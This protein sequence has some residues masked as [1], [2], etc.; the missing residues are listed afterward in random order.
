L[1]VDAACSSIGHRLIEAPVPEI[2]RRC[3]LGMDYRNR[4]VVVT[5]GAGALGTALIAALVGAGAK[6][7]VA[8][9]TEA[10]ARQFA[11]RE[12]ADVILSVTGD[13]SDEAAV[14][15]LFASVPELWAAMHLAGGFAAASAIEV[16]K[17]L[18]LQQLNTNFVS[19]FL[20]CRAALSA[21]ARTCRGGRIVNVAA[22]P[23]LE[24][25]AG[26]G[27]TA[28]AASKAAVA[29][30]T[31]ALGEEVAGQNILVNAVAPSILDTAANRSSMPNADFTKWPKVEDVAA[32]ILFLGSPENRVT[33]SAVVPVYGRS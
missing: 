26:A 5:G 31:V 9:T 3:G 32:T 11:L 14:A 1:D 17:D 24:W 28:Y 30:L 18:L 25:R 20:C 6:C 10:Q 21:M 12:H 8:C 16:S 7:H 33:R 13:L 19:C 27:M 22:R 4:H 23:A 29:A 15:E 2:N